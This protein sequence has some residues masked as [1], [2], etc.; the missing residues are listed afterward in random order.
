MRDRTGGLIHQARDVL[1]YFVSVSVIQYQL[2][3]YRAD[4]RASLAHCPAVSP[5]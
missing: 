1:F 2:G 4:V 3:S 5:V